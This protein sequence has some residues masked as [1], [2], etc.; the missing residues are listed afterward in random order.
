MDQEQERIVMN[1]AM[2][3]VYLKKLVAFDEIYQ[4]WL[5]KKLPKEGLGIGLMD[6]KRRRQEII[7]LVRSVDG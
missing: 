3:N 2:L 6:W 1:N 4:E 7:E 5:E